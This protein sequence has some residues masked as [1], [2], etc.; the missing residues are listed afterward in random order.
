V[1]AT[2]AQNQAGG[3]FVATDHQSNTE[4]LAQVL[5]AVSGH[6]TAFYCSQGGNAAANRTFTLRKN[7]ANT[8][9]TCAINS[10]SASGNTTGASVSFSAG[11]LVDIAL[12]ATADNQ[13]ARFAVAI[14]P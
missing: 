10:G 12:P 6:F 1:F 13:P 7:G 4:A 9:L 14:G 3:N 5:M 2:A 11:D 8:T